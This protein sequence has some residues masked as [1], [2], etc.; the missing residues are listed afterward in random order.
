MEGSSHPPLPPKALLLGA[1]LKAGKVVA[2]ECLGRVTEEKARRGV[3]LAVAAAAGI[4]AGAGAGAGAGTGALSLAGVAEARK[5]LM[6]LQLQECQRQA[7]EAAVA[8]AEQ[9]QLGAALAPALQPVV[10]SP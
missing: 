5:E 2:S 1:A 10:I 7:H 8:K 6:R 4:A 3:M 9:Q